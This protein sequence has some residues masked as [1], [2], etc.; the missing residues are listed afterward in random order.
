MTTKTVLIMRGLPGSTKST[1]AQAHK[2]QQI[3]EYGQRC[4]IVSA[5]DIHLIEGK[6]IFDVDNLPNAHSYCFS[7]FGIALDDPKVDVMIVDNTCISAWEIS[8]YVLAAQAHAHAEDVEVDIEIIEMRRS[9]QQC[10]AH[11]THEVPIAVMVQME[12]KFI[13]EVLPSFYTRR[14]V[15][16]D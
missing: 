14:L 1:W 6:Y 8:P 11:N 15:F 9:F 7:L 3:E 13:T 16:V 12:R 10:L 4:E 5:D 2:K